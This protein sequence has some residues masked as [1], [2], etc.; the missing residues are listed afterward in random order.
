MIDKFEFYHGAAVVKIVDDERCS[1]VSRH[2]LLGYI[3][4][5]S[6]FILLKYTAKSRSP[7]GFTFDTEDM[8][9]CIT[10][11]ANYPKIIVGLVCAGDGVCGLSWAEVTQLLNHQAGR[12]AV[13]RKHNKSYSVRGSAGELK[14]KITVNR[15][16]SVIFE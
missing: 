10:M 5:Q 4:N 12:I 11:N 16:P 3:V 14:H 6:T 9:R 1:A 2:G 15:W 8:S 13:S 7:W